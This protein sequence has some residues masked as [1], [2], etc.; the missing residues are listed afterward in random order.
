M[1]IRYTSSIVA[2]TLTWAIFSS[3]AALAADLPS[4][5][6]ATIGLDEGLSQSTV[7]SIA[8][9]QRGFM[10]FGT[11]DG[12]NR[13]DGSE[14]RIFNRS[15]AD[16]TSINAKTI[17]ALEEDDQGNLFI[18]TY[19]YG[20]IRYDWRYE[21]FTQYPTGIN[22]SVSLAGHSVYALEYTTQR[23]LWIG[24]SVLGVSCLDMETGLFTHYQWDENIQGS[25]NGTTVYDIHEDKNG[26]IWIAHSYGIDLFHPDSQTFTNFVLTPGTAEDMTPYPIYSIAEIGSGEAHKLILAGYNGQVAFLNTSTREMIPIFTQQQQNALDVDV[27]CTY[28]DSELHIWLGTESKGIFVLDRAGAILGHWLHDPMEEYSLGGN[29][30]TCIYRGW[31]GMLWAGTTGG[32]SRDLGDLKN[33]KNLGH[34]PLNENTLSSNMVT[35]IAEGDPGVLWITTWEGGLDRYNTRSGEVDHIEIYDPASERYLDDEINAIA[36]DSERFIWL[37]TD[38]HGLI[39][40]DPDGRI[41]SQWL[42]DPEDP[43]SIGSNSINALSIDF[44]NNIWVSS[45]YGGISR[46]DMRTGEVVNFTD[47]PEDS[48]GLGSNSMYAIYTDRKGVVWIGVE[49]NGIRRYNWSDDSFTAFRHDPD[50]PGSLAN[51]DVMCFYEDRL[52]NF[53]IGTYGGGLERYDRES[54]RFI[55]TY[56]PAT[57]KSNVVYRILESDDGYL[58]CSTNYG[59]A[60]YD[61]EADE[62]RTFDKLD[63]IQ[64]NEFNPAGIRDSFGQLHFG[65]VAGLTSFNSSEIRDNTH[66]PPIR[67]TDMYFFLERVKVGERIHDRIPLTATPEFQKVIK[68]YP[69]N[70]LVSFRFA[71]L[72][73][74]QPAKNQYAYMLE[75]F[76]EDWNWA[77]SK[78]LATYTNLP[79]GR[80]TFRAKGSNNDGYWNE[81]GAN[82]LLIV[83]SHFWATRWFQSIVVLSVLLGILVITRVRNVRLRKRAHELQSLNRRLNAE[84]VARK[85]AQDLSEERESHF[86]AV[87]DQSPAPISILDTAGNLTQMNQAYISAWGIKDPDTVLRSYNINE[88]N[89]AADLG[90]L[91]LFNA[92]LKGIHVENEQVQIPA[93]SLNEAVRDQH[94]HIRA[95]PLTNA[96]GNANFVVLTLEDITDRTAS[97]AE[98]RENAEKYRTLFEGANDAIFLMDG[99]TFIECNEKTLAIFACDRK[100]DIVGHTPMDFS[101]PTQYD[102]EDSVESALKR[103]HAAMD[104]EPQRFNWL[105]IRKDGTPFDAEVALNRLRLKDKIAI[106]AMV[107]DVTERRQ[108][109]DQVKQSLRE[110][111]VLLR[112]V[113][114]R[115]KNNLQIINSLASLQ[116]H[117]VDN[118]LITETLEEFRSRVYSMALVHEE[119][120]RSPDF[121]EIE[122][123]DYIN[124][125]V[126]SLG[127]SLNPAPDR[128]QMNTEVGDIHLPVDQAV[129]CGLIINELVSNALKY[130]FPDDRKGSIQVSLKLLDTDRIKLVVR[131]DGIGLPKGIDMDSVETLGLYLVSII[132]RDQLNGTIELEIKKGTTFLIEFD[133]SEMRKD[134]PLPD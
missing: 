8:Q 130:A 78:Q 3:G 131:D 16:S 120:Y 125:L 62:W 108:A 18:G 77:G 22:D 67:I 65:G 9:D 74:H 86:L 29:Q 36:L 133:I 12:L 93:E 122:L 132:T 116:S 73:Y 20:L 124:K 96:Q 103:I 128:V 109:E 30:V 45:W 118:D 71:S 72:D 56:D 82:I 134:L 76:D 59:L 46:I 112:E 23:K 52:G 37:G 48:L 70:P 90:L 80:Y 113:H 19:E 119:L 89:L 53:W 97:E 44:R 91:D 15:D 1:R 32:A 13:Y 114:H 35:D 83:I 51:N 110:K 10:W 41:R 47:D 121:S 26:E 21:R 64:S 92:A 58:W 5:R 54:N 7:W 38:T 25:F 68:L 95:Y 127:H 14:L 88:D 81:T 102:G 85:R 69:Q 4:P 126:Q 98:L 66:I 24:T 40:I 115:V 94:F 31:D 63:G 50:D 111:E 60:R 129:P 104:G 117:R 28:V 42:H 106:Q 100:E 27:L 101:P 2:G 49:R 57:L 84:V 6:F 55:H 79:A 99:H 107:R 34:N 61:R 123:S 75:G 33:F 105:H 17:Y 39:R 43:A 87:I 11:E